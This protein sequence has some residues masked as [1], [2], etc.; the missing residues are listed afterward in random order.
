MRQCN[1]DL[2]TKQEVAE[3]AWLAGIL[4]G[5]GSIRIERPRGHKL[6]AIRIAVRMASLETIERCREITHVGSLYEPPVPDNRQ[7]LYQWQI[8][9][10]APIGVL[11]HCLPFMVTKQQQA[12]LAL[13]YGELVQN[14]H[15]APGKP[16]P[17]GIVA[18]REVLRDKMLQLNKRGTPIAIR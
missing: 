8:C 7:K 17:G 11:R 6:G 14:Y 18:R 3:W 10:K 4:D 13:E 2:M 15:P 16:V 9:G 5:E 1:C 12:Q